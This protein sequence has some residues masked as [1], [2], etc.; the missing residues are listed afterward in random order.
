M[1]L[2]DAGSRSAFVLRDARVGRAGEPGFEGDDAYRC[3]GAAED[4]EGRPQRDGGN[5]VSR[6]VHHRLN[7]A[8]RF[9]TRTR[10]PRVVKEDHWPVS[11]ESVGDGGIP[12]V[13]ATAKVLHE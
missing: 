13:Q 6:V 10:H 12:M 4:L 8:G 7:G 11:S 2:R 1:G 9:A 5:E 3:D